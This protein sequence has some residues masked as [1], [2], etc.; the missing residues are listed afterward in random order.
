MKCVLDVIDR[1]LKEGQPV[2]AHCFA[3]VGRTGT[4]VGC[5]LKRKGLALNY[6]VI[7]KMA[8]LR[9]HIPGGADWSPGSE[10]QIV[11]IENWKEGA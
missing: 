11:M 6:E 1:S 9:R 8:D 7:Q 4:V 3:G 2:Y 10:E 5:Y